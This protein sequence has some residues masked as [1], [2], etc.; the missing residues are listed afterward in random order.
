M[1]EH[2]SRSENP[3]TVPSGHGQS[4]SGPYTGQV[5]EFPPPPPEHV[6]PLNLQAASTQLSPTDSMPV[7]TLSLPSMPGFEILC[8]LGRGGM[9]VVYQAR[10]HSLNRLVALK[11]L[12]DG[13]FASP[14]QLTRFRGDAEALA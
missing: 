2:V 14:E 8:E 10:Q 13:E 1:A 11:M 7:E 6:P 9:A 12:L 5:D 3:Q 4:N